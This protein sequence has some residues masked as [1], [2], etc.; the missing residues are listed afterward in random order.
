VADHEL[1]RCDLLRDLI[2]SQEGVLQTDQSVVE[3]SRKLEFG[4]HQLVISS[5]IS[6]EPLTQKKCA[7]LAANV[8]SGS[9]AT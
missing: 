5:M 6:S 3:I 1:W 8:F 7:Y 9:V 4:S 2:L